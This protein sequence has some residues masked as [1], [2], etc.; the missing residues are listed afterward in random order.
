MKRREKCFV[1]LLQPA[2]EVGLKVVNTQF[3]KKKLETELKF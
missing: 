2:Q 1:L 3:G